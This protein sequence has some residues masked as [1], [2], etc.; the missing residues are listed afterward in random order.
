MDAQNQKPRIAV[1]GCGAW[2]RNIARCFAGLGVLEAVVDP[3]PQT[4]ESLTA[5]FGCRG[6]TLDEVL[7]DP[8]IGALAIATPPSLHREVALAAIAAGKHVYIE[9]PLTLNYPD[10]LAVVEA[11]RAAGRILMTGHILQFHNGFRALKHLVSSG[12]LGEVKRV[13]ANRLNLG[14]VR[15]EEDALWCLA[16]HDVSMTLGLMG[17]RPETVEAFG[18][19]HLRKDT[20]DAVTMRLGFP[21]G[22]Q[23]MIHVSWLH[24]FK[25]HRLSV[26]GSQA[27][28]VFD[29]CLPWDKKV[30]I[31]P[32]QISLDNGAPTVVRADPVPVAIEQSEPLMAECAHFL[33]CCGSGTE[34][35]TGATEA[36][37]VMDVLHRAAL[38]MTDH[39]AHAAPA[40]AS[41]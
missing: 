1:I 3:N 31:Y 35:I 38:S 23:A 6:A 29:D 2:G 8:G 25:E 9:K 18:E 27:M 41:A 37:A 16:P 40:R 36:L 11:A 33:E 19:G 21:G 4:V 26:I 24:P 7:A 17:G 32:H 39:Q 22:A 34:P 12:R 20:A 5:L 10:A 28:A 15:K 30:Q 13:H 14:A